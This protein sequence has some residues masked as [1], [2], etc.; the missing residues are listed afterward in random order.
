MPVI[1][2]K[3]SNDRDQKGESLALV[4]L[5]N[6]EEIVIFEEAHRSITNL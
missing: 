3:L 2:S 4:A 1:I 5:K 6:V